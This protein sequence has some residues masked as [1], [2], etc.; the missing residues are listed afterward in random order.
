[1]VDR[2]VTVGDDFTLP[3]KVKVTDTHLP[4]R[5]GATEL[6]AT[7]A[8]TSP[9]VP[10]VPAAAISV[11]SPYD[12]SGTGVH[13]DVVDAGAG[14]WNGWRYWMVYTPYWRSAARYENPV[15]LVSNDAHNW[16]E[17]A[18]ITNPIDPDPTGSPINSDPDMVLVGGTMYVY[19]R[20]HDPVGNT[21]QIML[22]TSSDGITWSA[23]TTVLDTTSENP[24]SRDRITSPAV[25]HTGTQFIMY[26]TR[27]G[28]VRRRT[29]ADGTT[30]AAE[31]ACTGP[32]PASSH[33]DAIYSGGR[34]HLL[35]QTVGDTGL[36]QSGQ[37]GRTIVLAKSSDGVAFTVGATPLLVSEHMGQRMIYRTC[38]LLETRNGKDYYRLWASCV[39]YGLATTAAGVLSEEA[40]GGQESYYIGYTEGYDPNDAANDDWTSL[41][42]AGDVIAGGQVRAKRMG[43]LNIWGR[44]I[45]GV[46]GMFDVLSAQ[47]LR[48]GVAYMDGGNYEQSV[49][50]MPKWA[51]RLG[52]AAGQNVPALIVGSRSDTTVA[53]AALAFHNT[54]VGNT[55]AVGEGWQISVNE[56]GHLLFHQRAA[57]GTLTLRG[58]F[59]YATGD[60]TMSR[61][62]T[63]TTN[64]N[65][66]V[67]SASA[68]IATSGTWIKIGATSTP[69]SS[70]DVSGTVGEI[71]RDDNYLYVKTLTGWKRSALATW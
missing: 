7:Y 31:T 64:V 65:A 11:Q 45:V 26:A 2:V 13:P 5:L 46:R 33:V 58:Y 8:Q 12:N 14:K 66:A 36:N 9:M 63:T 40:S 22:R 37:G 6:N 50:Q 24:N 52:Y 29:S 49:S 34:T 41:Y 30:W 39:S 67:V 43:A 61:N 10:T 20:Q 4:A 25:V 28:A 16:V 70:A 55:R 62:V 19:Y 51:T 17:P 1:M 48:G 54:S 59:D 57:N 60:L 47:E 32:L 23:E 38:G 18:G 44:F 21:E 42:P 68:G 15:I 27:N 56:S 69:S 3:E 53:P 71:R 35:L